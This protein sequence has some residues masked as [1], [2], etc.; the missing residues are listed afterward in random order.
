MCVSPAP[1]WWHCT[2]GEQG[3]HGELGAHSLSPTLGLASTGPKAC[4]PQGQV[5]SRSPQ[6]RQRGLNPR[7]SLTRGNAPRFI[8]VIRVGACAVSDPCGLSGVHTGL[9]EPVDCSV[10]PSTRGGC[11]E[12]AEFLGLVSYPSPH[13]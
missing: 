12:G 1:R 13:H 10:S 2:P 7:E 11:G 8:L 5:R 6:W 4:C 9:P 3:G